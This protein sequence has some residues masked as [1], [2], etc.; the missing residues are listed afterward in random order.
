MVIVQCWTG[1]ETKALRQVMRLSIRA[2][3][4]H[5]GIDARTVN[6][7]EAR[8]GTITL[9]PNTQALMDTALEWAPEE[10][11]TRFT[12]T[13]HSA[14]QEQRGNAAQLVAPAHDFHTEA[15][16]G[17]G[18]LDPPPENNGTDSL[19]T[20]F[21]HHP[22]AHAAAT[23]AATIASSP[24]QE[25]HAR[26]LTDYPPNWENGVVR[27]QFLRLLPAGGYP[28][29]IRATTEATPSLDSFD[30][31]LV[32]HF[33]SMKNLLTD[34]DNLFGANSVILSAQEQIG[35]LQQLRQGYRGPSRQELLHIQ[36]QFADLCG[37]L[38]Q[39]SGDYH[40]AT[41]W[42]GRA[43]EWPHMCNDQDAIAFIL[44]RRSQL[45][46]YA[47]DPTE[48]IDAAEAA[49]NTVSHKAS[50][51]S[52]VAMT[53]AAHAHALNGNKASCERSYAM[54]Q[55]LAAQLEV[56]PTSPWDLFFNHSYI[57]VQR[58]HS[59]TTLDK[60]GAA[61]ELFQKAISCLPRGYRRDCGVY[62]AREAAAHMGYGDVEQACVVD[63]QALAIGA[64]TRSARIIRELKH[65]D[66]AMRNFPSRASMVNFHEAMHSTFSPSEPTG[67]P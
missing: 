56:D 59:L 13:V 16:P 5:L 45:A 61:I 63:L 36:V 51:V 1:A 39:D 29:A 44:A 21:V 48:A 32:A 31:D 42:S 37:W 12:Q 20:E 25:N 11:K 10:V 27:R 14:K 58:A 38:Y 55:D 64:E 24:A 30:V 35:N 49:L 6:K 17:A 23:S 33:K 4:A 47:G 52:T 50:R 43:L 34:N 18:S 19:S 41:Y 66:T 65:L 22:L 9:R 15:A 57:E 2:F 54:S 7:G 62:L 26:Q 40:A 28:F 60:Y 67:F 53:Y 8:R 46:G 3:A